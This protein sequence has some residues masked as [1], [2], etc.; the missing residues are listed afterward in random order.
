MTS[1]ELLTLLMWAS[2][3]SGYPIPDG[4]PTVQEVTR[5]WM[6][7]RACSHSTNCPFFAI[8]DDALDTVYLIP[9]LTWRA[10]DNLLVHEL[11]HYLQDKSGKFKDHSCE[12]I[13]QRE[14]EAYHV[15]RI[16]IWSVQNDFGG[17][18][19]PPMRCES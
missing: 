10:Q 3:L 5:E 19:T 6:H 1:A 16:Y 13:A 9:G 18:P 7:E 15:Q 12:N 8:Y 17:L 2:N 4:L 14:R 11:V